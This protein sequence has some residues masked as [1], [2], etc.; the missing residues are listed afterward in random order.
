M[1]A[2]GLTGAQAEAAIS[3][4]A[5]GPL[6][7]ELRRAEANGHQIGRLLP[8]VVARHE[9]NDADDVAAVLHHRLALATSRPRGRRVP[10]PRLIA[11]LIPEALGPMAPDMRQALDERR[12]LIELRAR[13]LAADAVRAKAPWVRRLGDPPTDRRERTRWDQALVTL[14][15]YRDRYSITSSQPLG[16]Q[17]TTDVQRLDR[18]RAMLAQ[19]RLRE[20]SDARAPHPG[21]ARRA[22]GM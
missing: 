2:S 5:F 15:A 18:A 13:E 14:A 12:D 16:D 21:V 9:L 8:T 20:A 22:I 1:R 7:A 3:S 11:G 17:A 6:T 4:E 10:S 19:A